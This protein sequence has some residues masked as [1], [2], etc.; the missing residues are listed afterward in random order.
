MGPPPKPGVVATSAGAQ[1]VYKDKAKAKARREQRE[2][3][4]GGKK[5]KLGVLRAETEAEQSAIWGGDKNNKGQRMPFRRGRKK[6]LEGGGGEDDEAVFSGSDDEGNPIAVTA[7]GEPKKKNAKT[8]DARKDAKPKSDKKQRETRLHC[9]IGPGV[10]KNKVREAFE[11]YEPGVDMRSAQKGNA[12]NRTTYAVL[13]FPNKALAYHCVLTM[14]G[15]DQ[16]DLLGVKSLKMG[17]MIPRDLRKKLERKRHARG[18]DGGATRSRKGLRPSA[19]K[20][21]KKGK[22]KG[23]ADDA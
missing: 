17:L 22:G 12:L 18:G 16:T 21:Q 19:G 1:R 6:R 2:A 8:H 14:D 3:G 7:N 13:T 10:H 9:F 5:Q 4:S 20:Q 23:K 11:R 15:S